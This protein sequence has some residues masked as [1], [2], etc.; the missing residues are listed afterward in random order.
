MV[1]ICVFIDIIITFNTAV[2]ISQVKVLED[3][4]DIAKLYIQKWFWIDLLVTIPYD[5]MIKLYNPALHNV[6]SLPKFIRVIKI[7]RLIRLIKL[8]K[9]AKDREKMA[10]I[11]A[12]SLQLDYAIERLIIS[13]FGF[14]LLCH[15]I[16]CLWIL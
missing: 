11:L 8:V 3:R 1:D 4:K 7:V 14:M 6:A 5:L 15:V 13:I 16:G 10:A 12:S 2:P 9:V